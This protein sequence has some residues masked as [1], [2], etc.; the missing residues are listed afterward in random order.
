MKIEM[1]QKCLRKE[2]KW[3][4]KLIEKKVG[5]SQAKPIRHKKIKEI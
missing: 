3:L 2:D 4:G 1:G 5:E